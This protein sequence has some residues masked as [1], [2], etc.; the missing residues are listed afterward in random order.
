M[1]AVLSV[2]CR[3]KS[4]VPATMLS[5]VMALAIGLAR[6]A[7]LRADHIDDE[8]IKRAPELVKTLQAKGYKN[9]GVLKFM[10]KAGKQAPNANIGPLNLVMATRVENALIH[11]LDSANPLGVIRDATKVAAAANPKFTTQT[12]AGRASLF[13]LAYPLAWGT[14]K[15]APDVL[16]TG[17]VTLSGNMRTASVEIDAF[18]R[19]GGKPAQML[20]FEVPTD[21]SIL[22][23]A[24]RSYVLKTRSLK[25]RGLK[26]SWDELD[27]DAA[28]SAAS[29]TE[30]QTV[31][32]QAGA[33]VPIKFE[34][35][36]NGTPQTISQDPG[37]LGEMRVN[38]PREGDVV[39]FMVTNTTQS[40]IGLVVKVNGE[41][42]LGQ[43]M[44][45]DAA[46][47]KW[48]LDPGKAY[49]LKGFYT[50]PE[51]KV[52][53]FKVLSDEDSAARMA[54]WSGSHPRAGFFDVTVF[55][56][57]IADVAASDEMSFGRTLRGLSRSV[58]KDH[59]PKT[60][61]QARSLVEAHTKS[62]RTKKTTRGLVVAGDQ[63]ED[64]HLKEDNL[65]NTTATFQLQINY[66]T[67][68]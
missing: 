12:D 64:A 27:Q 29:T 25:S 5:F 68:S 49:A 26:R 6:P 41:S 14:E 43:D 35:R 46:C 40:K 11:G 55:T 37:S 4:S 21:R 67:G 62:Q 39:T 24:G 51:N 22:A 28:D 59:H 9:V 34:I 45:E 52:T 31:T 65:E 56:Q 3:R 7:M 60:A 66:Y 18:D 63:Q 38:E 61:A 30:G 16:L 2:L 23:D 10:V 17:L 53:L 1:K 50:W 8:L 42:T 32:Q 54:E 48:F 57:G 36:Y 33:E 58:G 47:Q 13:K 20:R 19:A 44:A 15:V